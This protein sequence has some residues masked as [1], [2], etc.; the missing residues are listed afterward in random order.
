MSAI[1]KIKDLLRLVCN[2]AHPCS[3]VKGQAALRIPAIQLK[4]LKAPFFKSGLPLGSYGPL[5]A[6]FGFPTRNSA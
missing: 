4:E 6:V 3:L 1:G 5:R 2:K